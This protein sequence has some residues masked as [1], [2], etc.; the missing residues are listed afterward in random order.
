MERVRRGVEEI[1]LSRGGGGDFARAIMTTDTRPKEAAVRTGNFTLAGA[2]KGAGMI[3][4]RMATMLAFLTTDAAVEPTFL[5]KALRHAVDDSFNMIT[6]D[7][8]TSTNDMVVI[9]ANGAR[10]G[11]VISEGSP[12]AEE[13]QEALRKLCL[14]LARSI[15]RDGEGAS[16]LI[17][18]R[19][20]GARS[21]PE[22]KRAA[23]TIAGSSLVKT[24]VYGSHPN[25]GR[26][27]AALGRSGVRFS[28][29]RLEIRLG[30]L[31]AMRDG[32]PAPFDER[33]ARD[34]LSRPE[35]VIEVDLNFGTASAIAW[36]CDLTPEYVMINSEYI[37]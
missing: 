12:E 18:V 15:A 13:F 4:P 35:V 20:K 29:K 36:G 30:D 22:A 10:R 37:T 24:A 3:H 8:D 5:R 11:E 7:G 17:E 28:E 14:F 32:A 21:L 34:Y 6:V 2:A 1:K 25:W 19:V 33:A 27:L 16:K 23:R 31:C 26:V 9:L